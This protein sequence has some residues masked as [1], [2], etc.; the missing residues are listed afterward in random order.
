MDDNSRRSS[1]AS[2]SRIK[3]A[4]D[5]QPMMYWATLHFLDSM[6]HHPSMTMP[7]RRQVL[8]VA[9]IAFATPST[10]E[11]FY[12]GSETSARPLILASNEAK[13]AEPDT[14][15]FALMSG[16]CSTLKIAGRDFACRAVAYFHGEQGRA[17][18]T[19][20]LDDPA[21]DSHV[22]SF[23]GENARRE[24]KN[25]LYELQIDRM[26][27]NS[28]DRPKVDG[29][30]V[31]SVELSDG[32]CRQFGN[33]AALQISSISCSA[34]DKNGKK[35]ELQ[36]VSDGKPITLRR[37]RQMPLASEKRRARQNEQHE[38]REKAGLARVLPRDRPAYILQCLAENGEKLAPA[39]PQ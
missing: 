4:N 27:L 32:T 7:L 13:P 37:I 21:D 9:I 24:E 19:I 33:L 35:Y 2:F 28:K 17:N 22:I 34:T 3:A 26:L 15:L 14:D 25:N 23:S 12:G 18:F 6:T 38:C 10:A 16:K 20:A 31:P 36:F 39:E 11:L 8:A 29:L 5:G 30:P 1:Q